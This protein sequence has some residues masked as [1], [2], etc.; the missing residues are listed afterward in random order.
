MRSFTINF[1]SYCDVISLEVGIETD[2]EITEGEVYKNELPVVF[3]GSSITQGGC[4]SR[5]GNTY[6]NVISRR[7]GIDFLNLGFSGGCKA[8]E[9]IVEY[10][11]TLKMSTFVCDYDHNAP[12]TTY[13]RETHF[14][15]YEKIRSKNPNLPY[16]MISL[17]GY[18]NNPT[19]EERRRIII[20]SYER[21]LALGDRNV[22]FID[23]RDF[24]TAPYEDLCTVDRCHPNDLGFALMADK[25]GAVLSKILDI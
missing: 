2:A 5:A 23:G 24:F 10:L 4:S 18:R 1:P 15:L 17:P 20:D 14:P 21:A 16:V 13:L 22:Y 12:N 11:S 7:L 6:Q 8:E 25:I 19:A 3:Y 9:T